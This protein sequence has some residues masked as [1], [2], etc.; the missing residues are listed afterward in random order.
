[1]CVRLN[2]PFHPMLEVR[3]VELNS[4]AKIAGLEQIVNASKTL[5]VD[6]NLD[7]HVKTV[8][9]KLLDVVVAHQMRQPLI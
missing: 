4:I 1:M 3:A 9:S 8:L 2:D 6:H 7:A 5:C